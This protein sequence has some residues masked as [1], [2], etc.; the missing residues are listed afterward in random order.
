[1]TFGTEVVFK[2]GV[3]GYA[4]K[5]VTVEPVGYAS[6]LRV[7]VTLL[8]REPGCNRE[9]GVTKLRNR[10]PGCVTEFRYHT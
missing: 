7:N 6:F 9:T 2:P 1:M 5:C 8:N 3:T 10:E 4:V